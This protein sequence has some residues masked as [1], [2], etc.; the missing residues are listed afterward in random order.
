M[1]QIRWNLMPR[2][3]EEGA[4]APME[5]DPFLTLQSR[6][7][8]LFG[9]AWP[10]LGTALGVTPS[11]ARMS[12][13]LRETPEE[14]ILEAELPGVHEEDISISVTNGVLS[15]KAERKVEEKR[16]QD[17]WYL[18]ERSQGSMERHLQLPV[19]VEPDKAEAH[20]ERGVLTL[21]LPKSEKARNVVKQIPVRGSKS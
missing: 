18:E 4:S 6:I 10:N 1:N 7:N 17:G 14:L 21:R 3:R 12:M 13:D 5:R 11:A 8:R 15:L 16:E 9:E 20:F 19:E 2:R